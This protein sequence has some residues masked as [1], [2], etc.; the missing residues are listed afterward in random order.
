MFQLDQKYLQKLVGLSSDIVIAVESGGRIIYFNEGARSALKYRAE[1]IIGQNVDQIYPTREEAKRVMKAMRTSSDSGRLA[2][3]ETIFKTKGG[4]L[5]PVAMSGSVIRDDA[6]KEMGSIGFARDI[7]PM[8]RRDQLA[9]VGELAVT[10]AHKI[11]NPLETII[12]RLD[13]I[14]HTI[15]DRCSEAQQALENERISS[16][17]NA[18]ERIRKTLTRLDE[19]ARDG[20]YRTMPY[21]TGRIMM[22]LSDETPSAGGP[23]AVAAPTPQN[24]LSQ[25]LDDAEVAG[26]HVLVVDDDASVLSSVAD[27]LRAEGCVVF[28]AERPSYALGLL[29][30]IKIDAVVSDVVMPEMDGYDFYMR[31]KEEMPG[32]PVILMTGYL[33]DKDHIMKRA[34]VEGL[35]CALFNKPL[36]PK[37]LRKALVEA[38]KNPPPSR[39]PLLT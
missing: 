16:I 13:L 9:T 26:M 18:V 12:N 36:N 32:C 19:M 2:S 38:R 7:R 27:V 34:R 35:K 4:E 22:D 11:N 15:E 31:I 6:G 8:R 33:Y 3:F 23:S 5:I 21:L 1:E 29:R 17:R 10:L 24:G 28:T 20:I 37:M 30:N 14:A 39:P 25:P